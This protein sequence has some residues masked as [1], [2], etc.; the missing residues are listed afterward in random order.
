MD[1]RWK[2]MME[3]G[4]RL[5]KGLIPVCLLALCL[6]LSGCTGGESEEG[7]PAQEETVSSGTSGQEAGETKQ[8]EAEQREAEQK[9]TEPE[10]ANRGEASQEGGQ[11]QP[12]QQGDDGGRPD[13]LA[14]TAE[15]FNIEDI[16]AY[17]GAPYIPVNNNVPGFTAKDLTAASFETYSDLDSLGRC[18]K[19]YASVGRDLMPTEKRGSISKVKP[20]GWHSVEY[21]S[22][23]GKSLYNRCHL[24]GYQLTAENANEKNLITGTRYL[25]TE[26]MLPF[27]NMVADYVKETGNHVLYR[28]TPVFEGKNLVASGVQ[29]EGMS[30]E[31]EGDEVLFNVYCYNVQPGIS[32]NY[33]DGD[34]RLDGKSGKKE[35]KE[36]KK[37]ESVSASYILNTSTK[38]FHVP[39]CASVK[40]M[41]E[42]NTEKFTGSRDEVTSMGYDPCGRCNP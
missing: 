36:S 5:K 20:S 7:K 40:Q 1:K 2:W 31:D 13:N 26:G 28:V 11:E 42:S 16:P 3:A 10:E 23:E 25:N 4:Q 8:E 32:I 33:A 39:S 41:K 9:E 27:E 18:G 6:A 14:D 34:S 17:S 38:K 22:V 21:D 37:K 24:I 19:A 30:V 15:P 12:A 35:A 29:I